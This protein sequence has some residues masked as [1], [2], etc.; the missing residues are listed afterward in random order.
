MRIKL[1]LSNTVLL[2]TLLFSQAHAQSLRQPLDYV[3]PITLSDNDLA[4][5]SILFRGAF[6]NNTWQGSLFAYDLV[7]PIITQPP[8][9]SALDKFAELETLNPDTYWQT[10]NIVFGASNGGTKFTWANLTPDERA[11]LGND[12]EIIVNY[13]R[14]DRTEEENGRRV[15]GSLLGA[16]IRSNPVYI[17]G[18]LTNSNSNRTP[19][20]YVGANDGMLHAF[21]AATGEETWA[22][23]PS[24]LL[25]SLPFLADYPYIPTHYVDGALSAEDVKF[26]NSTS[27]NTVLVGGLGAGGKGL[28]AVDVTSPG[29]KVAPDQK[30]LWELTS[31]SDND[32]GYVFGASSIVKLGDNKW[33]AANGNGFGSVSGNA[34]LYLIDIEA[35][36]A[37][38]ASTTN[39]NG[40][41]SGLSSPAFIDANGD[42]KMDIAYAGDLQGDLWR[43]N[44]VNPNAVTPIKVYDGN[45]NQPIAVKPDVTRHPSGGFLVLFGTGGT[46]TA[47]NANND[48]QAII[49]VRDIDVSGVGAIEPTDL[50]QRTLSEELFYVDTNNAA[51]ETVRTIVNAS[52]KISNER[53]WMISLPVGEQLLTPPRLRDGRLRASIT[54]VDANDARLNENWR[55]EVT[56]VQ[57]TSYSNSVFD[58]NDDGFLNIQD[59]VDGNNNNNKTEPEDIPVVWKRNPGLISQIK[60]AR[61]KNGVDALFFNA[62]APTVPTTPEP[63]EPGCIG[64]C[65]GG[66]EGGHIDVDTDKE[67]YGKTDIHVHEYDDKTNLTYVDYFD[68]K[69]GLDK[70]TADV[71]DSKEF[72][73][74]IANADLSPG[75]ELIMGKNDQ[76]EDVTY[77]VA[78]Y[79]KM[80]H[81]ALENWN[82]TDPLTDPNGNSLIHTADSLQENNGTLR[83]QFDSRVIAYG[84]IIPSDTGCV[85]GNDI[86]NDRWRNGSLTMHLIDRDHFVNDGT[87]A[88]NKVYIQSPADLVNKL[89]IKGEEVDLSGYGGLLAK[90]DNEFLYESTIFWHYGKICYGEDKY[91]EAV[92][93]ARFKLLLAEQGV[94]PK[95]IKKINRD[96]CEKIAEKT[97]LTLEQC[98]QLVEESAN[99]GG[100]NPD[101]GDPD[102]G[103]PDSGDPIGDPV[104]IDVV[105][106]DVEDGELSQGPIIN[107]GRGSWIDV[108]QQ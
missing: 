28:F 89:Y 7:G 66:L 19:H 94:D 91:D 99:P 54:K 18:P 36:T 69:Q 48:T 61:V 17:G 83:I 33:Y 82:G 92:Q 25:P 38:K 13:V 77:N 67:L 9:M 22:Y 93:T 12:G 45:P 34:V 59:R 21:D 16:I 74:L 96:D 65:E 49:G 44:L 102:T 84:G 4:N 46:Y 60:I 98:L 41:S 72:I 10:R 64:E 104:I 15:R 105:T 103:D 79:Q 62:L 55:M 100:G 57:G 106:K 23:I 53:G 42:G 47:I 50:L 101:G 8:K 11:V 108:L 20:V 68:I 56:F 6:E 107:T 29:S 35:G 3:G 43:F 32:M 5:G 40:V 75:A 27:W 85:R 51:I 1:Y 14:G 97:E 37:K 30:V 80:L 31:D 76:G 52:T 90:N 95:L 24:M 58:L 63:P 26:P 39:T 87:S 86:Y 78:K 70:V 73:I 81:Q 2:T 88:L 71:T